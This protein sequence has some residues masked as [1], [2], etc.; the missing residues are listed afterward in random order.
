MRANNQMLS[1]HNILQKLTFYFQGFFV[2]LFFP[3]LLEI[4]WNAAVFGISE[5]KTLISFSIPTAAVCFPDAYVK[6]FGKSRKS[7][8][9]QCCLYFTVQV[10]CL[11]ITIK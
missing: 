5:P 1:N 10:E 9:N 7:K 3:S 6:P 11:L 2:L 8:L 4:P